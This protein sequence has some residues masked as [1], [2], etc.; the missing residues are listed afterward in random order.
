MTNTAASPDSAAPE[1]FPRKLSNVASA[2]SNGPID[3][4]G[5]LGRGGATVVLAEPGMGKSELL[6]EVGRRL[7]IKPVSA[8]R[9]S[10]S[11]DPARFVQPGLPLLIDGLDEAM[12]RREGDAVTAVL[13]KL[14]DAGAPPFILTC[15]SREWQSR[16]ETGLRQLYGEDPA[17]FT[18]EPFRRDEARSFLAS[19]HSGADTDHVLDHLDRHRL[20][21]LYR[22]PLTLGL[23]GRV[24]ETD[25]QLPAT[26]GAL[27][28]RV[29]ALIWPEHDRD[30]Q[31]I[32]LAQL[33]E[34]QALDAAGA[35][36]AALLFAGAESVSIA[37]AAQLQ[38]G[39]LRLADLADLPGAAAAKAMFSS[40]LFV[41]IGPARAKPIHRVIAE[42]LGAR[43][44]AKQ[45]ASPRSQ[46]RLL[47]QC[48]GGG[49]VPASLRGLHAWLAYHSAALAER[50]I[51]ADPF[52]LLRYGETGDLSPSQADQLFQALAALAEDDPYFRASDWDSATA[53]GLMIAPL[54]ARI[55][56]V[57]G[58]SASNSHLR[59]LLIEA[60]QGTDLARDLGPTLE[61]VLFDEDRFYREREDAAD[62]LLQHRD[63]AWWQSAVA[64]L[65]GEGTEDST[66]LARTLIERIDAAV[67]DELLVATLFA[68]LGLTITRL[69]KE[70][71]RRS[72]TLR[73]HSGI[74]AMIATAR[75]PSVLD[76]LAEYAT[77]VPAGDWQDY[78][79]IA[80]ISAQLAT[81]A[82]DEGVVT[83]ADAGRLWRWLGTV[84]HARQ[85]R[86]ESKRD[87]ATALADHRQ[88][89]QAVQRYVLDTTRR[90]DSLRLTE[91][92]LQ[93]RLVGLS[94]HPGDAAALLAALE[95]AD[96][97]DR[98]L[99]DD[100]QDLVQ[101][102][103]YPDGFEA[104][105]RKSA[106]RF[107]RGDPQLV[108]FLRKTENPKPLPWQLRHER[109]EAK[110]DRKKRV[111]VEEDRRQ[112]A[113]HRAEL[114]SGALGWIVRPAQSYLGIRGRGS[115]ELQPRERLVEWL[116]DDLAADAMTGLEAV[117]HRADLP[118]VAQVTTGFADNVTYNFCFA[119][120]AGLLERRRS[121]AG[122][123][124]LA[125]DVL[126][127][128]LL[129]CHHDRGWCSDDDLTELRSALEAS[130]LPTQEA[131]TNF[132]RVW[133]EPSLAAAREHVNGLYMLSH[134]EGWQP[135]GGALADEWLMRFPDVPQ[136]VE[137]ELIECLTRAGEMAKLRTVAEARSGRVFRDEEHLLTWLAV[138]VLVRFDEVRAD[139]AGIGTLHPEFIW[140]LRNRI[141]LERRGTMLALSVAQA[142]WI[143]SEFRAA[144][145]SATLEGSGSGDTN[146]Y[147]ATDFLG[148]LLA[149]LADDGGAEAAAALR[150]LIAGPEDS[151]SELIR[152]MAAE[153]RQKRAEQSFSA[154]APE[155][156][157]QLLD[158]GPPG[159]IDDLKT[160]VLEELGVAQAKL[161]GED[162]DQVRDFWSDRGIPY[163]E[164]RCRDRLAAMI[165]PELMRYDIQRITEADMP[166]TKRV[167]LAFARGTAQLP[168]EV[169]G[170][171]HAD[172][173]D[174][175]S[176]Q[177]DLQ[178]LIDWRSEQRGIY[179]VLWF[180]NL[181]SATNRR[182]KAHPDGVTAPA[183]ADAM[184]AL[185]I[186][187]IP[188]SRRPLIEVIV[189][190]LSAGKPA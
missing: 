133:I 132:A 134:G 189:L 45:A 124:G 178:Y 171:W 37:G 57:I 187:R 2:G 131:R 158:D 166:M 14:D 122:F 185:L 86:R 146:D 25:R 126:V 18:L 92:D 67:S 116:G 149:R 120:M 4:A 16:G 17:I 121:G 80:D 106:I 6:G 139:L 74:V 83:S 56:E 109:E 69:P 60:V 104:G 1:Y 23:M 47:A 46:R 147:D 151:Y 140:F 64:R 91:I 167:D 97:R 20:P 156:L 42:F 61:T 127:T 182:L 135:T 59:S 190:D 160:L 31:D 93:R 129:L 128:G 159:N 41:G 26:R 84:E 27:F 108:A 78:T 10:L 40:N 99:R 188:E 51:A 163:S 21:D 176:G 112:F 63:T 111:Q 5:L 141:Q 130:L 58:S 174:A 105:A 44:L 168:L 9:F 11:G 87:L 28:M 24:A 15:R 39:D 186:E 76:L 154:V 170:Q 107:A 3:E 53:T 89:R 114:R 50:V 172:V 29:C 145:P 7:G 157:G 12:A 8:I 184:Q 79:D 179:C 65:R 175:A 70:R 33:S 150:G 103:H 113:A 110:R 96:N 165:G 123:A 95:D 75:L 115:R 98:R 43:W 77:L 118:T 71:R 144:W 153:Q 155:G 52:G 66:R 152:H 90:Q 35:I 148:A 125:V 161:R 54:A 48:H 117:L 137:A 32:G 62:A 38:T 100:W 68:E 173:W 85:S 181:P 119:I 88:L 34:E 143:W 162:L 55:D 180:G 164:N 101:I 72:H 102:A 49:A 177:L 142:A 136:S 183:T 73:R 36:A 82:I 13:A 22:N 30:R 138:D 81:R 19:R 169:K 94:M